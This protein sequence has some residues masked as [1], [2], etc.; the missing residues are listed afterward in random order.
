M[1]LILRRLRREQQG[2]TMI[3]ALGV[4]TVAMSLTVAGFTAVQIDQHETRN[5]ILQKR[6]LQAAEAGLQW[7]TFQLDT[8]V[9][10][11]SQC[12][13]AW[14]QPVPNTDLAQNPEYYSYTELP[15]SSEPTADY[16]NGAKACNTSDPIGSMIESATG[17]NPSEAGSFR[18]EFNGYAQD[19]AY[20]NAQ[21]NSLGVER[22]IVVTFHRTGFLNFVYYTKYETTYDG[23]TVEFV[24]GD[25]V[26]GPFH[27]EDTVH[28][29]GNP[30][31]GRA[32]HS[33]YDV[34]QAASVVNDNGCTS[35]PTYNTFNGT[36]DNT[37]GG[38]DPPPDN[39]Q[40][41]QIANNNGQVWSGSTTIT[42]GSPD[43]N[44]YS[45]INAAANCN[46][47]TKSYP[48]NGVIFVAS[49]SCGWTYDPANASNAP[50]GCGDVYV[51]G[52]ANTSLTIAADDDIIITGDTW[53]DPTTSN[54]LGLVANNWV[55]IAHNC[56]TPSSS[57][58][59]TAAILAVTDSFQVDDYNCGPQ[60]GNINLTGA[61]AQIY[62][63]TVG[64]H[65]NGTTGYLKNY[66]Y[67]DRLLAEEPPYFLNPVQAAWAVGRENECVAID[68]STTGCG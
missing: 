66:V 52:E 40:L 44:H 20:Q 12:K 54:L 47:C 53:T 57:I 25:S 59:I 22:S 64:Q 58:K 7:Y 68:N 9:N 60:M 29:C 5:D 51:S 8:N 6:A 24:T 4:M 39:S 49:T 16:I 18:V 13:S 38:I 62:R 45:V 48:T 28:L 56:N 37:K 14:Q 27:T 32:N 46:P 41:K 43:A 21:G 11:W 23:S 17:P 67:D 2:V 55:R 42:L 65:G 26:N 10:F 31:F 33:P 61:I 50:A 36:Y 63:G 34:M 3:I 19:Y 35:N 30:T 15:A 1:R